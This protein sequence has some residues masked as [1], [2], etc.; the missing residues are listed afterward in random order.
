MTSA[1]LTRRRTAKCSM[2]ATPAFAI[3]IALTGLSAVIK[4]INMKYKVDTNICNRKTGK[5]VVTRSEI[6]DTKDPNDAC[7]GA[8]SIDQVHVGVETFWN[9]INE[10]SEDI[11]FV[12]SILRVPPSTKCYVVM[13][14]KP[15]TKK[16]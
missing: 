1:R 10:R 6:I 12:T 5:L 16:A 4:R 11:A 2:L 7:F 9:S 13:H 8:K 3:A 15:E 14:P